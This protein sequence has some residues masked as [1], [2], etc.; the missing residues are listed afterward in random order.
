MI[1]AVDST[2]K[3]K[4]EHGFPLCLNSTKTRE[5][6]NTPV[7][8]PGDMCEGSVCSIRV[9]E[10]PS[11]QG[12]TLSSY[13][14]HPS[15][16]SYPSLGDMLYMIHRYLVNGALPFGCRADADIPSASSTM[17]NAIKPSISRQHLASL[18]SQYTKD[19]YTYIQPLY[20]EWT[21]TGREPDHQNWNIY[22]RMEKEIEPIFDK[23]VFRLPKH[24]KEGNYDTFDS[25]RS[26]IAIA[27]TPKSNV[28]TKVDERLEK[29]M[30]MAGM[31]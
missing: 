4:K 9:T 28:Q 15:V 3:T 26:A 2:K 5:Y 11:S 25:T 18:Y 21:R 31:S 19:Y 16:S 23:I 10:C 13:H 24:L 14:T 30:K 17:C 29:W 6:E 7:L 20:D 12:Q 1:A 22:H 8:D 27:V